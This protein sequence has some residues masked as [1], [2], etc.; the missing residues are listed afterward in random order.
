[1]MRSLSRRALGALATTA[2]L[3]LVGCGQDSTQTSDAAKPEAQ[4]TSEVW[5]ES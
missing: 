5:V 2:A 1:M 3:G 4:A